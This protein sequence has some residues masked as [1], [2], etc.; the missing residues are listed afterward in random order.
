MRNYENYLIKAD[1]IYKRAM[2]N[3]VDDGQ[4]PS[5]LLI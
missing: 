3:N 4:A 2:T 1:G 5:T